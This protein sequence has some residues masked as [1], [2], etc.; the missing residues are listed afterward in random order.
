MIDWMIA[1]SLVLS[2]FILL[3]IA[4][5]RGAMQMV[6][7]K[8]YYSLWLIIPGQLMF[9]WLFHDNP[10]LSEAQM[11]TYVVS[12]SDAVHTMQQSRLFDLTSIHIL[13][14]V[15][16][17]LFLSLLLTQHYFAIKQLDISPIEHSY[18]S[19]TLNHRIKLYQSESLNSPMITGLIHPKIILPSHFFSQPRAVQELLLKHEAVHWQRGD[20]WWNAFAVVLLSLFWFNP[21]MWVG[22]RYFRQS[23]EL[24][25]DSQVLQ[26][27]DKETCLRYAKAFLEQSFVQQRMTFTS[28][29]YGGK[30]NMKDRISN[31]RV[32]R[33][34]KWL[35]VPILSICLS[36]LGVSQAISG[37][38]T[39]QAKKMIDG[40]HPVMRIEPR[41]P[42]EAAEKGI[43][44]SVVLQFSVNT[45]GSVGDIHIVKS[46]PENVFD[47]SATAALA[48]WTYTKPTKKMKNM[49]VQLDYLLSE[50]TSENLL[51]NLEQI[52]VSN[53][54]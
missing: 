45:D 52:N 13:W 12:V 43:E 10:L 6:G 50:K 46:V 4:I 28:L 18:A 3:L 33:H 1:Q 9:S 19:E 48:Q 27:K 47:Q 26:G 44:G 42:T 39:Q 36:L 2:V 38:H 54:K 37:N 20:L 11:S 53:S 24:A 49:L 5:Y 22:Y 30:Q 7:A 16:A 17:T 8:H 29:Y 41:Y 35:F 51:S 40:I 15:G 14:A 32:Q 21:L 25:C 31:M 34:S 23:Q